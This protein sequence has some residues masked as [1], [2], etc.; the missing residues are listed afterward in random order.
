MI[1][2]LL[3]LCSIRD[4]FLN[5]TYAQTIFLSS[6]LDCQL[7]CNVSIH[8]A[9]YKDLRLANGW[10]MGWHADCKLIRDLEVFN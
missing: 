3:I 8:L 4:I 7:M 6:K 5:Q 10:G 1:F 2:K 9:T